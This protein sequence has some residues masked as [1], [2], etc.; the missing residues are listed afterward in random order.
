MLGLQ[1]NS[2]DV[3]VLGVLESLV[4]PGLKNLWGHFGTFFLIFK[5][6]FHNLLAFDWTVSISIITCISDSIIS[7]PSIDTSNR[8]PQLLRDYRNIQEAF[9]RSLFVA[10]LG[11][12]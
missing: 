2:W 6:G 11:Q 10:N 1:N 8:F 4:D 7:F 3:Q 9:K 12:L 5:F